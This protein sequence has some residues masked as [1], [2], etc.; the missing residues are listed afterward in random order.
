MKAIEYKNL[1]I[2]WLGHASFLIT[3]IAEDISIFI[4]PFKIETDIIA[5][6]IFITHS[7]YDHLS[8]DDII[9][10]SNNNTKL[11]IPIDAKPQLKEFPGE[12][13]VVE[14]NNNYKKDSLIIETIASYNEFKPYHP[15]SNNWVGYVIEINNKRIF[16]SGDCDAIR[17]I[18]KLENIDIAFLPIGGTYTMD[19]KEAA[20]LANK[21]KPKILIPMHYGTIVGDVKDTEIVKKIFNGE[22]RILEKA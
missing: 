19:A 21:F 7:H 1:K 6:Y 22:T 18:E 9:S 13:M 10:I 16:H 2:R 3:S 4:D 12:I 17:E 14:P 11:F 5:D 15:K 20:E 8:I